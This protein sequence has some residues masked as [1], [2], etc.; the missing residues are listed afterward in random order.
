MLDKQQ[1][2]RRRR[3]WWWWWLQLQS[4]KRTQTE[5]TFD[6]GKEYRQH[7]EDEGCCCWRSLMLPL[8]SGRRPPSLSRW[9]CERSQMESVSTKPARCGKQSNCDLLDQHAHPTTQWDTFSSLENAEQIRRKRRKASA[10]ESFSPM[11]GSFPPCSSSPASHHAQCDQLSSHQ[12][13]YA[14]KSTGFKSCQA[15]LR[16]VAPVSSPFTMSIVLSAIVL[17]LLAILPCTHGDANRFCKSE[18]CLS[19]KRVCVCVCRHSAIRECASNC[20]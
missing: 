4:L 16:F 1:R 3:R 15:R 2:L 20:N 8:P 19:V 7:D 18:L 11:F 10:T 14:H 13:L 12:V 5:T 17:S 9:N 6:I